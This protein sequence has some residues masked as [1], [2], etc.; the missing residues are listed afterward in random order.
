MIYDLCFFFL[1]FFFLVF[2]LNFLIFIVFYKQEDSGEDFQKKKKIK[3]MT[4][5][6][7]SVVTL[8]IL[9]TSQQCLANNCSE[10]SLEESLCLNDTKCWYDYKTAQCLSDVP[11][12][13]AP[14]EG[15][16]GTGIKV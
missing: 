15:G 13:P 3:I 10:Y 6:L 9:V 11:M 14:D 4:S 8:L 16:L 12:T 7:T 1:F 2:L 5:D